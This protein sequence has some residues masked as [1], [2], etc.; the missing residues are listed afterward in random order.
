MPEPILTSLNHGGPQTLCY[1]TNPIS[2]LAATNLFHEKPSG[3]PGYN[4]ID[5][6]KRP[7][8]RRAPGELGYR[9]QRGVCSHE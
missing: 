9:I 8:S 7:F 2:P 4:P 1:Q 3:S 6:S 5:P